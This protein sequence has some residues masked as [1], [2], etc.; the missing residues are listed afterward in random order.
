ML[1]QLGIAPPEVAER[2]QALREL[3]RRADWNGVESQA[4]AMVDYL[5]KTVP[6][7][8]QER[9]G[10]TAESVRRFSGLGL[11]A[12]PE[13]TTELEALAHP[14][15][16]EPWATTVARLAKVE[17][18]LHTSESA[19]LSKV[20]DQAVTV[21]KWAGL[22]GP[23]LHEF[24]QKLDE[25]LLPGKEDR[26]AEAFEGVDRLLRNGLPESADRRQRVR[27]EGTRLA[28]AAKEFG[29]PTSRLEAALAAGADAPPDRWPEVIPAVESA[30]S[31]VGDALRERCTQILEALRTSLNSTAE[32]GV[33]PT[34]ARMAVEDALSRI[35]GLPALEIGPV[36]L[37]ARRAAEEP[38]VTVVAGLLDEARP[39]IAD[40]RRLGRDP[41]EVFAAMNRA[42]EALRLKIY[43]EAFA[44]SQE[45]L[46][47]VSRLTEELDTARDEFQAL[48]E[49]ADRFKNAGFSVE[50]FDPSLVRIRS[51]LER[52]DVGAAHDL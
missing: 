9:R 24:E 18:A 34:S 10:R 13:V 21:A 44:A 46:D 52:V 45:A 51:A 39:R 17:D 4:K 30:S 41:S 26:L 25:A 23:R 19:H 5:S 3:A 22:T 33:D 6:L 15:E 16:G 2:Q 49:M 47:K 37:E 43:S 27:D 42:R 7:S 1:E 40:A 48:E 38:I 29:A 8:I 20:R 32:Y 50:A 12:P 14:P 35:K 36:F 31:E 28:A 11:V